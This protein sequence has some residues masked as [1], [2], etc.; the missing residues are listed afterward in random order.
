MCTTGETVN[1]A[2]ERI[3][4]YAA[5]EIIGRNVS[6]LMPEP[7]HSEHDGY[8][9]RYRRTGER[10][11]IGIGREVRGRRKDGTEF[12]FEMA[13]STW[14]TGSDTFFSGVIRDISEH[15]KG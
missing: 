2:D 5:S 14:K 1:P 7:Y 4:G 9:E 10:R 8:L 3:F 13:L 15:K 12:L 6:M 11:I